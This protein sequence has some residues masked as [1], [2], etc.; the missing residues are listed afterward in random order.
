MIYRDKANAV[1]LSNKK[2]SVVGPS[3]RRT[4]ILLTGRRFVSEDACDTPRRDAGM[5]ATAARRP[6]PPASFVR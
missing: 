1:A 5:R 2:S 4:H 3:P 6:P